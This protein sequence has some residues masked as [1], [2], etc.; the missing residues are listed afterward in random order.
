MASRLV[1]FMFTLFI[2]GSCSKSEGGRTRTI[3]ESLDLWSF[4]LVGSMLFDSVPLE[5]LRG[6]HLAG[7]G[8]VNRDVLVSG[9]IELSG[10]EGT[11]LVLSDASARMLV[12]TTKLTASGLSKLSG[13]G[14]AVFVHGEV[15]TGDKGHVYLLANAVRGG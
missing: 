12:D 10:A 3:R 6:V 7:A 9:V 14:K 8:L 2:L 5:D 11:Y 4:S 13:R 1:I 15:K